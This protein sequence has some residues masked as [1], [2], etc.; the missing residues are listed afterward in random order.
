MRN[1][2]KCSQIRHMDNSARRDLDDLVLS[3]A[4]DSRKNEIMAMLPE[5]VYYM[6]T[7]EVR[8]NLLDKLN[9]SSIDTDMFV[10][11]YESLEKLAT[12]LAKQDIINGKV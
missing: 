12:D 2:I 6:F 3:N 1:L 11:I 4:I 9:A 8:E 5:D 10:K 7:P